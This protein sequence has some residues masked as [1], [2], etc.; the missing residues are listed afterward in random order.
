MLIVG[1][2]FAFI[3]AF[4]FGYVVNDAFVN[5]RENARKEKIAIKVAIDKQL[6][7]QEDKEKDI[8]KYYK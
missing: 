2:G 4:V 3:V 6:Q 7:I 5:V 1:I 8:Y